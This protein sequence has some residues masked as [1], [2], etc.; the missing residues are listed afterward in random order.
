MHENFGDR[1]LLGAVLVSQGAV[2]PRDVDEAL[3]VQ[4]DTGQRLGEALLERRLI[5][6]P[7]LYR[8]MARQAGSELDEGS[9]FGTGLRAAIERRHRYRRDFQA[10]FR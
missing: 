4:A 1:P 5:S 10:V 7:E 6:R 3:T 9:G 2:H 8:A